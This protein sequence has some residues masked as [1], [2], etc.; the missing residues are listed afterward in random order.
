MRK[1]PERPVTRRENV[2]DDYHGTKVADPYRWLEDDTSPE[3]K[4]WIKQQ[5]EYYENYISGFPARKEFNSRLANL[6]HFARASTPE[7][8][9]DV[10]ECD[11]SGT[12]RDFFADSPFFVLIYPNLMKSGIS[13]KC[14]L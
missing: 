2:I 9:Y 8:V 14:Y 10:S 1:L 6:W 13:K 12:L 11:F 3:V 7:F 4:E 5:D